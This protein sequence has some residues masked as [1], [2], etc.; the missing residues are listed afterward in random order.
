MGAYWNFE[1]FGEPMVQAMLG[2]PLVRS[3]R[4]DWRSWSRIERATAIGLL[5]GAPVSVA[6]VFFA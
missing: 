3:F 2:I 4:R 6:S 5:L 1:H